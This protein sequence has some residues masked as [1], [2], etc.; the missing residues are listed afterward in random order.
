MGGAMEQVDFDGSQPATATGEA[1]EQVAFDG[2]QPA[3]AV[4]CYTY[5]VSED[6]WSWSHAVYGLHGYAPGEV[7]ATTDV[8]LR[9]KHPD[10]RS[11][12][13][14]VLDA[15][16]QDG[17]PFSCYHRIVD[18]HELVRSVL[19]VGRGIEDSTGRVERVEGYFV[20]LTDSK[21]DETESEVKR[22][23][24]GMAEN[25]ETIDLAKGMVM[26]ATGCD[27]DTAFA[28]LRRYSHNTNLKLHV[29]AQRLVSAGPSIGPRAGGV[30]AFLD[31]LPPSH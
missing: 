15:A 17:K 5:L 18:R 27:P 30:I 29:I 21:R 12:A 9:H 26:L 6:L 16:V 7:P 11:R 22:A 14:E 24:A 3:T 2:S 20:D 31:D 23:L 10:D 1:M 4:G 28:C 8:L 13:A 25:R 19:S